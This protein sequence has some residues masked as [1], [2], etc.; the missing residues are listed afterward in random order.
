MDILKFSWDELHIENLIQERINFSRKK[1]K[2][3]EI[4]HICPVYCD[5]LAHNNK[6]IN[7]LFSLSL[8]SIENKFYLQQTYFHSK[9]LMYQKEIH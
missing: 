1:Y 5:I 4:F 9:N 2:L 8:H 6:I 3:Y 7:Q